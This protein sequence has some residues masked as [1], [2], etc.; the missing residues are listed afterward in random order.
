MVKREEGEECRETMSE[1]GKQTSA[2]K[3]HITIPSGREDR[4]GGDEDE[5]NWRRSEEMG[6]DGEGG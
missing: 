3:R 6:G 2:G 4:K 1:A 5:R